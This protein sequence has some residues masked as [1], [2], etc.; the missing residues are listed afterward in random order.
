VQLNLKTDYSLRLL[1]YLVLRPSEIVPVGRVARAFDISE[2]HL[3]KVSQTLT[4]LGLVRQ[5]RGRA[6]GLQITA[7]PESVKLGWLVRQVEGSLALVECFD[8]TQNTCVIAPVCALKG[9]LHEAQKAFF[10]VLDRYS[11]A[12]V[13]RNAGPLRALLERPVGR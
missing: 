13:T 8:A 6:G 4:K 7:A 2:H 3:A 12:D 1:L 5:V 9:A 10:D 11:L